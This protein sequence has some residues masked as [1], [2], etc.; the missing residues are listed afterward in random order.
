MTGS[1]A[2]SLVDA[3]AEAARTEFFASVRGYATSIDGK[4]VTFAP[5]QVI[6]VTDSEQ[7]SLWERVVRVALDKAIVVHANHLMATAADLYCV[8]RDIREGR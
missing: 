4:R 3:A 7:P 6:L 8:G 1:L 2:Q 5:D